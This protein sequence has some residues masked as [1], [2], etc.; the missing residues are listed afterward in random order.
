[1]AVMNMLAW[2]LT[3]PGRGEQ[4]YK[5]YS[6]SIWDRYQNSFPAGPAA[7]QCVGGAM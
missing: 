7:A 5:H 1:M 6:I 4:H 2:R 3:Q